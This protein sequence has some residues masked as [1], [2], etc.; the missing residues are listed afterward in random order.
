MTTVEKKSADF[1][2]L[3]ELA[4]RGVSELL[5]SSLLK[6]FT[7]FSKLIPF[8][9]LFLYRMVAKLYL[10]QMIGLRLLKT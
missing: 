10:L 6:M 9:F 8:G 1:L 4:A 5:L 3:S 7:F 2:K